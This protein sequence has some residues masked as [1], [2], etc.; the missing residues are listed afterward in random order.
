MEAHSVTTVFLL[1]KRLFC[2]VFDEVPDPSRLLDQGNN[3]T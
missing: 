1:A 3:K 2:N